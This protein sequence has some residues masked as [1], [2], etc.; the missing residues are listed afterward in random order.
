MSRSSVSATELQQ[1]LQLIEQHSGI[2]LTD[3]RGPNL[4][5]YLEQR[6]AHQ[7]QPLPL[8]L[9]R[10]LSPTPDA[11]ELNAL[12]EEV[13]I[14]ETFFFRD[15]EQLVCFAEDCLQ[16]VLR[17]RQSDR[18]L[19][20]WSAACASGEEPYTLAIVLH[21]MLEE[22][23]IDFHITATDIDQDALATARQGR[24]GYQRAERVLP[25]EYLETY[26]EQ[27]DTELQVHDLLKKAITFRQLNLVDAAAM[28]QM[29]DFDFVFCKNVLFYFSP[30]IQQQVLQ[31]LYEAIRPGGYLFLNLARPIDRVM[32][33]LQFDRSHRYFYRK[34]LSC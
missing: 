14:N 21:A 16:D 7:S 2:F 22:E 6:A 17:H 29:R 8:Y 10:L 18:T 15:Y 24:Y 34:P 4:Q 31:R 33:H 30:A 27:H 26:F 5:R 20:I 13:A 11:A 9:R 1:L 32:P 28:Q 12:V 3:E 19:Q 23:P 25:T